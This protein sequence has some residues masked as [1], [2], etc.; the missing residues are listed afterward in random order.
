MTVLS[1][2]G[3][4]AAIL[5]AVSIGGALCESRFLEKRLRKMGGFW[6]VALGFL[7]D[8]FVAPIK[9]AYCLIDPDYNIR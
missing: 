1:Y 8:L 6:E 3:I 5:V 4:F 9:A 7:A 2:I